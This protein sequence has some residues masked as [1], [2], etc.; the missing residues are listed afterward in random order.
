MKLSLARC[1]NLILHL[2]SSTA[3]ADG[4]CV[5]VCILPTNYIIST[6]LSLNIQFYNIKCGIPQLMFYHA[7]VMLFKHLHVRTKIEGNV[8]YNILMRGNPVFC[9]SSYPARRSLRRVVLP[10]IL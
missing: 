3:I 5:C 9:W 7:N 2:Y 10:R 8:C 6:L 4:V 1:P